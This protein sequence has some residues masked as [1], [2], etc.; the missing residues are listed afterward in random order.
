MRRKGFW[1][2]KL[3]RGWNKALKVEPQE[4]NWHEI[5]LERLRADEGVKGLKKPEDA[6]GLSEAISA[7]KCRCSELEKR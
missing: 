5:R 2:Q 4:R 6:G 7:F 1:K 3:L